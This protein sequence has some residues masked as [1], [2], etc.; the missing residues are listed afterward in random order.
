MPLF[1]GHTPWKVHF[2]GPSDEINVIKVHFCECTVK[3]EWKNLKEQPSP[4]SSD[5]TAQY[6][7]DNVSCE[8]VEILH[9]IMSEHSTEIPQSTAL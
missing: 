8:I 7:I 9:L 5:R 1:P 6:S 4:R 2:Y 3:I